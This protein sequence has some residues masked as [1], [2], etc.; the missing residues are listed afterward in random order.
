MTAM[1][2]LTGATE[3]INSEP[4]G[5]GELAGRAVLV[6]F[7]T[8]TCINWL[9]TEPYVR[10]W[11]RA[12]RDDGLVVVGVHTPEF[13]FERETD[14]VRHAIEE[15]EIEYAVAVDND[16]EVW[17]AFDNHFWPALYL[18]DGDGVV[19]DHQFGEGRYAESERS[20]Q[21][22]LGLDRELVTGAVEGGG[23]EAEADWETLRTPESYLGYGRG[24]GFASAG[25][26]LDER[27]DYAFPGYLPQD[28][29]ALDGEWTIER[30]KVRLDGEGGS[31]AFRFQA[32]DAHLV[33]ANP[34]GRPIPFQ[35]F[36]DGAKPGAA[37]GVDVDAEGV[38]VLRE[39]RLYQLIRQPGPVAERILEITF[40]EPG[41]E[42][43]AFTFG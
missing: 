8:L 6:D 16:Y 14:L 30:E 28:R 9:R 7:W 25:P 5:P 23:V 41:A 22:L 10:A 40:N 18:V 43:Y 27:R 35:V 1:P 2:T 4:L 33:L 31:I 26:A 13:T 24:G 37:H 21:R 20:V 11:D 34:T 19:R 42:G 12:Y 39:G 17:T 32:R 3:W 15:R 38:G 29:W 36:L